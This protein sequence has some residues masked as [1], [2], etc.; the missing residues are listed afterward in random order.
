MQAARKHFLKDI[1]S[2]HGPRLLP[3]ISIGFSSSG[4]TE[5]LYSPLLEWNL[6]AKDMHSSTSYVKARLI[7]GKPIH[8]IRG[9]HRNIRFLLSWFRAQW[10]LREKKSKEFWNLIISVVSSEPK[11]QGEPSPFSHLKGHAGNFKKM[12]KKG[13]H[14]LSFIKKQRYKEKTSIIIDNE[15]L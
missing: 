3:N 2:P 7:T 13:W 15:M 8:V 6:K 12:K 9:S 1:I 10:C 14:E 4:N 5:V 11:G